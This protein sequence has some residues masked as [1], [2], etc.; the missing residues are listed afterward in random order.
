MIHLLLVLDMKKSVGV[1]LYKDHTITVSTELLISLV[2][3]VLLMGKE[4]H[5]GKPKGE[6]REVEIGEIQIATLEKDSLVYIIIQDTY[7]NE[8]FTKRILESVLEEFH[9]SFL[10]ENFTHGLS[11][12]FQ[13]KEKIKSLITTMLFPTHLLEETGNIV[14]Q[15]LNKVPAM[16]TVFMADLD[17][18]IIQKWA[19]GK[20]NIIQLLMEILSEIPFERSWIGESKLLYPMQIDGVEYS[21]EAWLIHRVGL[22]DFC[23]LARVYYNIS[24]RDGILELFEMTTNEIHNLILDDLG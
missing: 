14:Y 24:E 17:D 3:T 23:L 4:L 18:G 10:K 21:H 6:L 12:E 5:A 8:P 7:D 2:Q 22:T 11:N 16:D 13:V 20:G 15:M 1:E 19:E 9:H